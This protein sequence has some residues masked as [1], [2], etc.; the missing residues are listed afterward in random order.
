MKPMGMNNMS[1]VKNMLI[2]DN[3]A[4]DFEDFE[5]Y[6]VYEAL[7][8]QTM[9]WSV[10]DFVAKYGMLTVFTDIMDELTRKEV[11]G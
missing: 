8:Y 3:D 9:L 1:K 4:K 7:S 11:K 5:D 6:A 2:D 10:R